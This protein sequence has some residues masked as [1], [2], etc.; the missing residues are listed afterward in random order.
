MGMFINTIGL[1]T[2]SWIAEPGS[3]LV[4]P[5]FPQSEIDPSGGA[6][7]RISPINQELIDEPGEN[8][9]LNEGR[10][11]VCS[12][13]SATIEFNGVSGEFEYSEGHSWII[14]IRG[15]FAD[16][17]QDSDRNHTI[18]FQEVVG[19]H[20]QCMSYPG[21]GFMSEGNFKQITSLS[22]TNAGSCGFEGC[23]KLTVVFVDLNTG[24]LTVVKQANLGL[25]W[26]FELS[27]WK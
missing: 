17:K 26:E 10:I 5:E 7:E 6:L 9:H 21:G 12:F 15:L 14:I 16:G 20:A 13:G 25:P 8:F 3:A 2:E 19:S 23:S 4:G 27:N 11:D 24:A 22:H 18:H 1:G